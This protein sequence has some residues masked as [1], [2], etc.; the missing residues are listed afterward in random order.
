LKMQKS[1]RLATAILAISIGGWAESTPS[2]SSEASAA[3]TSTSW[4]TGVQWQMRSDG[5]SS[6]VIETL[7]SNSTRNHW[8][9]QA[10]DRVVSFVG[11]TVSSPEELQT[12][13]EDIDPQMWWI[14]VLRGDRLLD[15]QPEVESITGEAV[16]DEPIVTEQRAQA[17]SAVDVPAENIDATSSRRPAGVSEWSLGFETM[18]FCPEIWPGLETP[19]LTGALVQKVLHGSMAEDAGLAAGAI[20]V[21]VDG[22]R[23]DSARELSEHLDMKTHPLPFAVL[24]YHGRTLKRHRFGDFQVLERPAILTPPVREP[25]QPES[26]E[27]LPQA[28]SLRHPSAT[29]D[30]DL[31]NEGEDFLPS[32]QLVEP[33]RSPPTSENLKQEIAM[34]ERELRE[35]EATV[36]RLKARLRELQTPTLEK[37]NL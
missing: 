3:Q 8:D 14:T 4:F 29:L 26:I 21:A 17:P 10:G 34:I 19:V 13:A 11:V 33:R 6:L 12:L 32:P 37:S 15:F 28:L 36:R 22:K 35:Q 30:S 25:S 20:I 9:L 18:T 2:H 16:S 27:P 7:E 1:M 31:P 24:A 23:I 5:T